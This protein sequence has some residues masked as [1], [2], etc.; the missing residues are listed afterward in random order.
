METRTFKINN[1][2]AVMY[3]SQSEKCFLFIHG[4]QGCKEEGE[5]FAK[6]ACRYGWQVLAVDLPEHGERKAESNRFNPWCVI[7][8]L[9]QV[10]SF[11]KQDHSVYGLR[12]NSI[13]AWFSMQSLSNIVFTKCLFVSPV[14]DMNKLIADMMMWS[15][16]TAEE[17]KSRQ[18]IGTDFGE[19]LS[20][21]YHEFAALHPIEVWNSDTAVLYA[22]KDN[23]TSRETVDKFVQK[24]N[25]KL[26]VMENGEHWFHTPEQI[27]VL[28]EWTENSMTD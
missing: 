26:T 19:T 7:P 6:T 24:H 22:D 18:E 11:M 25:A 10:F 14:L 9:R 21:K 13:G 2:P 16:V 28:D 23:L 17:L 4:K 15:G 12:A 8:E 5:A 3:G 1:I 20:W 27:A